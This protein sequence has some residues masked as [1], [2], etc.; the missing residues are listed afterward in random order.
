[1]EAKDIIG[2]KNTPVAQA[3]K[4]CLACHASGIGHNWKLGEHSRS[5]VTCIQCHKIHQSRTPIPVAR[6]FIERPL[7]TALKPAGPPPRASLSKPDPV[8]CQECHKSVSARMML[9]SRHPVREGK[10]NCGSCHNVHGSEVAGLNTSERPNDLCLGCH[11]SKQGPFVFDHKPV[12][13]S[14][15]SCHTPHGSVN[16]NLLK[17][18]EPFLCLQCHEAHFHI[19]RS[20]ASTPVQLPTGGSSNPWGEAGWRRAFGTKC[21]QCHPS[22]HGSDLPGQSVAG[23]GKSLAR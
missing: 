4:I 13:E 23:R 16:N 17:Q 15:S 14:C 21:T 8:L 6:G 3:E 2:F 10:M 5:G 11:T 22:V 7:T 18:N 20:G 12:S 9:P 1:G 19:G